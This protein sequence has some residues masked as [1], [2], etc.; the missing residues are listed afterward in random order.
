MSATFPYVSPEA[1]P[2]KSLLQ[3]YGKTIPPASQPTCKSTPDAEDAARLHVA[4]GG[5]F[6]T[7]GVVSAAHW[8]YDLSQDPSASH[9]P[10]V[11]LLITSPYQQ[12]PGVPWSWQ[13]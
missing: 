8:I 11:L 3:A 1:R 10:I 6:D 5:L 2:A 9:P 12:R 13:R 4:D 7:T